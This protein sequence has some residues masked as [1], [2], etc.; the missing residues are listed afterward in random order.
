MSLFFKCRNLS[1]ITL[2]QNGKLYTVD[3]QLVI[4]FC[5]LVLIFGDT[6][7]VGTR[8]TDDQIALVLLVHGLST[9]HKSFVFT[10]DE[11]MNDICKHN[12]FHS[13]LLSFFVVGMQ[14][15]KDFSF[16]LDVIQNANLM[17]TLCMLY[18]SLSTGEQNFLKNS[19]PSQFC[20]CLQA[21]LALNFDR[22]YPPT[23]R[24]PFLSYCLYLLHGPS[25]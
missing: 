20:Q 16:V 14:L 22:L 10:R 23:I 17:S 1:I 24:Y 4:V 8:I 15:L 18:K 19:K 7:Q 25:Q 13:L 21:S 6:G 5:P 9:L 3:L 2:T 12:G 11:P